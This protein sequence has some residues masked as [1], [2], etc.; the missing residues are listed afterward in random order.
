MRAL[1]IG[2]LG[3]LAGLAAVGAA[4]QFTVP[5]GLPGLIHRMP[6]VQPPN[7]REYVPF[8]V[9]EKFPDLQLRDVDG[10]LYRFSE[11]PYKLLLVNFFE[12][13]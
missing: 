2:I 1:R 6:R 11:H 7:P 9:G 10:N 3:M 12:P 8:N 13:G 4:L 5:G